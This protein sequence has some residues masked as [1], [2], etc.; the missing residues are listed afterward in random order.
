MRAT[1]TD[2]G[3]TL[4]VYAGTT[5]AHLA[6]D[7][8]PSLRTD[9]LGFAIRRTGGGRTGG[10]FLSGGIG[11]P[12]QTHPPGFFLDTDVAPIQAFRW[13]D[14]TVYPQTEYTYELIPMSAPWD[15][16][17]PGGSVSVTV[18]TEG[19]QGPHGVAFNRAVAASQAF[20]R[21]FDGADPH[22]N[23]MARQW[24]GRGL[25]AFV[26]GFLERASG[27]GWALD[28]VVYEYELPEI[29]DALKAAL[30]RQVAIRIVYHAKPADA[31]TALNEQ[32]LAA[33]GLAG[34]AHPRVTSS[35]CHDKTV[36][37]SRFDGT[38]RT[39]VALL[40]GSTNWTLNGLFYQANVAHSVDDPALAAEYL[41]VFE[42]LYAGTAPSGTKAW[43]DAND[44]VAPD[45]V[46]S[47]EAVFSPRS[48]RTD[49]VRYV[50]MI[51]GA[52]R[53]LIFMT[54]FEL[55]AE[56][57]AALAGETGNADVLRYGLQNSASTVTGFDRS[58]DRT[59]TAT[60]AL[61]TTVTGFLPED[62][63]AQEGNLLV[64]GKIVL[65]DFDTAHPTLITGSAN[66]SAS[67]SGSNDENVLIVR[68]DVRVAD[69]YLCELF[70]L[71]DHYRFRYN[72]THPD[73][74]TTIGGE[75][76]MSL[77]TETTSGT[78]TPRFELDPSDGWTARYYD[79]AGSPHAL[80]RTRL[81]H[82]QG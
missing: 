18:R 45:P 8:D 70:R 52:Q 3:L 20:E 64:H 35:I 6:W 11:F 26:D 63:H 36:V 47:M 25:D 7:A 69:I 34:I 40:S 12:S 37:L 82:P 49:L 76:P 41:R 72:V 56:F 55:D 77:A 1:A 71:F 73:A 75:A 57:L 32:N 68:D 33:D 2:H 10:T 27:P 16:L 46:P 42:Q 31:Q 13:G 78:V 29:R 39:P 38:T 30:A 21:R 24:L 53:S 67:S 44:P 5:G 59:F 23:S 51:D 58:H 65:L 43:I 9:L 60:G 4:T 80:E 61:R 22:E 15:H 66:F 28:I 81:A 62:R 74:G 14:Y 79:D 48:N 17:K 54:A 50:E 19:P